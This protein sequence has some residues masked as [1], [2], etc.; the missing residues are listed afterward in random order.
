[1][2]TSG[3]GGVERRDLIERLFRHSAESGVR[4]RG[5]GAVEVLG[6]SGEIYFF[7]SE[8]LCVKGGWLDGDA[9]L[10]CVSQV[11]IQVSTPRNGRG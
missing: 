10:M 5:G 3:T 1:M 11:S 2:A 8:S 9:W 6:S 7:S 4:C